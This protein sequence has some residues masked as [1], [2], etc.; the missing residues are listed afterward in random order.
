VVC[1][2]QRDIQRLVRKGDDTQAR[3]RPP[4]ATSSVGETHL[5]RSRVPFELLEEWSEHVGTA[6]HIL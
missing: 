1:R 4:R 5:W 6:Q 3:G 2:G